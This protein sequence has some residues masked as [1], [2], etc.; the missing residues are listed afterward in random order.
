MPLQHSVMQENRQ[1]LPGHSAK[2]TMAAIVPHDTE[3][4][5][6]SHFSHELSERAGTLLSEQRISVKENISHNIYMF[7]VIPVQRRSY[8]SVQDTKTASMV[9]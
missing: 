5:I 3:A 4:K 9:M 2:Q 7:F 1:H 6:H 8:H